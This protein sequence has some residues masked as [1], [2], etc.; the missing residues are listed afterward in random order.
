MQEV[1]LS[2]AAFGIAAKEFVTPHVGKI[3]LRRLLAFYNEITS[4]PTPSSF[5]AI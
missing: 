5:I 2:H 1:N 4:T 3:R